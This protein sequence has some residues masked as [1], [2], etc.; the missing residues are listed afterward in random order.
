LACLQFYWFISH[1]CPVWQAKP[2]NSSTLACFYFQ[3]FYLT[4]GSIFL[5][6]FLLILCKVLLCY[7]SEIKSPQRFMCGRLGPQLVSPII[8]RWLNYK[9]F[10]HWWIHSLMALFRC[11][12]N[13]GKWDLVG[14]SECAFVGHV[15]S[16]SFLFLFLPPV[17]HELSCFSS[18]QALH[19]DAQPGLRLI[20]IERV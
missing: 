16:P 7:D 2:K 9:G 4:F 8:K 5:R 12:W 19:H 17:H 10:I 18:S 11:G 14:G 13:C 6:N 15:M 20:A 1:L 3:H